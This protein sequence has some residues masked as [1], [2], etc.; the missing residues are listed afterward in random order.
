MNANQCPLDT[1]PSLSWIFSCCKYSSLGCTV[2]GPHCDQRLDRGKDAGA[3]TLR[4]GLH[5][6]QIASKFLWKARRVRKRRYRW[7]WRH[8]SRLRRCCQVQVTQQEKRRLAHSRGFGLAHLGSA[9]HLGMVERTVVLAYRWGSLHS[10]AVC[11]NTVK[12]LVQAMSATSLQPTK[13]SLG[14]KASGGR[15]A[16]RRKAQEAKLAQCTFKLKSA[17]GLSWLRMTSARRPPVL[18]QDDASD[19]P[20]D[21]RKEELAT[22]ATTEVLLNSLRN[23]RDVGGL[24]G[25]P[26]KLVVRR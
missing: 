26:Q 14:A 12:G 10:D 5:G 15:G 4:P 21:P 25:V 11:R 22:A 16:R 2:A 19:Q 13:A 23:T 8:R 6:I 1:I 24:L 17:G 20:P 3:T 9:R 18:R 7:S